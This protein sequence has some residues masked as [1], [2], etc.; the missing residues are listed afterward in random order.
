MTLSADTD[1]WKN[2]PDTQISQIKTTQHSAIV[3]SL[4]VLH[5]VSFYLTNPENKTKTQRLWLTGVMIK[6][7]E[8]L[9]PSIE[10]G[11]KNG[12]SSSVKLHPVKEKM[13][14][15]ASVS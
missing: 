11:L 3:I 4:Q 2:Q 10:Q 7:A 8:F 9:P 1:G 14:A 12:K 5:P 15:L 13:Q 6:G